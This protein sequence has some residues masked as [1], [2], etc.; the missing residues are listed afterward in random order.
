MKF[1]L[2]FVL[3]VIENKNKKK[4]LKFLKYSLPIKPINIIDV[5]AHHGESLKLFIKNFNIKKSYE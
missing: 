5:G 4:I 3:F 2:N 1:I